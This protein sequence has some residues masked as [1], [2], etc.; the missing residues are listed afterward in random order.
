MV[1]RIYI[2]KKPLTIK[3]IQRNHVI[4]KIQRHTEE[5]RVFIH[6]NIWL[7]MHLLRHIQLSI[8]HTIFSNWYIQQ[9]NDT[10]ICLE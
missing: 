9:H 8:Q 6:K 4:K 5:K 7:T 1:Y 3:S 2:K 10:K